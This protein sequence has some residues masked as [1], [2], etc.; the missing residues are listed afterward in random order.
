MFATLLLIR[1]LI[2]GGRETVTL[3]PGATLAGELMRLFPSGLGPFDIYRHEA[4]A[5][6]ELEKTALADYRVEAGERYILV[7]RPQGVTALIYFAVSMLVSVAV[8]VVAKALMPKPKQAESNAQSEAISPNNVLAGQTN[9]L[10]PGARVPDILGR[11]RCW[12]DLIA[13]AQETWNGRNQWLVEWFVLGVGSYNI[14]S[15]RLGETSIDGLSGVQLLTYSPGSLVPAILCV[16]RSPLVDNVSLLTETQTAVSLTATFSAP[17]TLTT[18]TY[19]PVSIT[20]WGLPIRVANTALN[21]GL[22]DVVGAPSPFQSDPP[23]IYTIIGPVRNETASNAQIRAAT[24]VLVIQ[25]APLTWVTSG[26]GDIVIPVAMGWEPQFGQ[27]VRIRPYYGVYPGQG[28]I[29]TVVAVQND[30]SNYRFWLDDFNGNR[31]VITSDWNTFPDHLRDSTLIVYDDISTVAAAEPIGPRAT[32]GQLYTPWTDWQTAPFSDEARPLQLLLDFAFPQGLVWYNKGD[33]KPYTVQVQAEFKRLDAPAAQASRTWTYTNSTQGALRYTEAVTVAQLGLPAGS[34]YVQTRVR[35]LTAWQQDDN[36][37]QYIA[38]TRWQVYTAAV[39][40][41]AQVY[42][43]VTLLRL[44]LLNTRSA[45]SIGETSLNVIAT[46]ILPTWSAGTWFPPAPSERWADALVARMKASD[47]ANKTDA[48]ID[49]AGIYAIQNRLEAQDG[50]DQGRIALTLDQQQDI[51]SEL[52]TIASIARCQLYRI[53]PRLYCERDEGG[54][55]AIALFTGRSKHPDA[56]TLSVNLTS[57]A[58]PD[59]IIVPWWDRRLDAWK[60]REYQYPENITAINPLR[61]APAQATWAQACRRAWYEWQRLT[62]RRETLTLKATEEA[63]L[64][65]PGDVVNVADDVGNLSQSSGELVDIQGDRTLGLDQTVDLSDGN[66]IILLRA[67]DGRTTDLIPVSQIAPMY[68]LLERPARFQVQA[69]G[70]ALGTMFALYKTERSIV[71]PWL[72]SSIEPQDR[73][74]TISATNWTEAVFAGDFPAPLPA[75][76]VTPY[77]ATVVQPQTIGVLADEDL[78]LAK[79]TP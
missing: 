65:H 57:D 77:L 46:R 2:D 23:F 18:N 60:Q 6:C 69:R 20:S 26:A 73:Y 10:R 3:E 51:D 25:S 41:P 35:R 75:A 7:L 8:S 54:K 70:D 38:D 48:D 16:K 79:V 47:G 17:Q 15:K 45:A 58:D 21:N 29:G 30:G 31:I 66:Y 19:V 4:R 67:L 50:G 63:S 74:V 24:E 76:P 49:L 44:T 62:L 13:N 52:Q 9:T 27:L 34:P 28:F 53:G 11:M 68:V 40:I 37:N 43:D 39:Q 5:D 33:R 78:A 59:A 55:T 12:P 61:I 14:T 64:V 72:V 71:A 42:G 22:F 32:S 36:E 1:G 56:E